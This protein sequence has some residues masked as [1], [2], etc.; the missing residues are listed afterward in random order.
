MSVQLNRTAGTARDQS[1]SLCSGSI[2]T[3]GFEKIFSA[4]M[5][6]PMIFGL[7][8][9]WDWRGSG[10]TQRNAG[11]LDIDWLQADISEFMCSMQS[12]WKLVFLCR[13]SLDQTCGM[14]TLQQGE[15]LVYPNKTLCGSDTVKNGTLLFYLPL[16][17]RHEKKRVRSYITE[18]LYTTIWQYNHATVLHQFCGFIYLFIYIK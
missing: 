2:C 15:A 1:F 6:I 17:V 9:Q 8:V 16:G 5:K 4:L 14:S 10:V 18:G 12:L 7:D 11:S 13:N 3:G